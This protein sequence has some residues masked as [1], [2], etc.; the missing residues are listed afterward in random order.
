MSF[1][2]GTRTWSVI[3]VGGQKV[4]R[5][6]WIHARGMEIDALIYFCPIGD[7]CIPSEEDPDKTKLEESLEIWDEV[8]NG[9]GL[10]GIPV[11]LFFNKKDLLESRLGTHPPKK[12]IKTYDGKSDYDKVTEF[13]KKMCILFH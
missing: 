5:K 10:G 1:Q 8:M 7:Y 9:D 4:E 12:F 13:V 2:I 6:K 3:D 11:I